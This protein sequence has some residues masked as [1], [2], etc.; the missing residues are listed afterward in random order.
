VIFYTYIFSIVLYIL[1]NQIR[2]T[3][4]PP[5]YTDVK[6]ILTDYIK[7][8]SINLTWFNL[9]AIMTIVPLI[10][11]FVIQPGFKELRIHD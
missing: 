10:V 1:W 9:N 8:A 6:K 3:I 7:Y 4:S 2:S 11:I 5:R